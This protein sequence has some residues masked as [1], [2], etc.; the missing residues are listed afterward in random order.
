M[1]VLIHQKDFMLSRMVLLLL[2][3]EEPMPPLSYSELIFLLTQQ[4][5][6]IL[7]YLM[8]FLLIRSMLNVTVLVFANRLYF[9]I[10]TQIIWLYL[11]LQKMMVTSAS[12][13]G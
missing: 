11:T 4:I 1:V 6:T 7:V 8:A 2:Q 3:S 9:H 13:H 12:G 5:M 10:M